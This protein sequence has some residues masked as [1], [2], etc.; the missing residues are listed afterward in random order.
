MTAFKNIKWLF[1]I[2]AFI[3]LVIVQ[4]ALNYLWVWVYSNYINPGGNQAF[5][6]IYIFENRFLINAFIAIPLYYIAAYVLSK[7][8]GI[9]HGFA[10]FA[11]HFVFSL[12]SELSM[13]DVSGYVFGFLV[14]TALI[15]VACYLGGKQGTSKFRPS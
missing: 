6:E 15:F 11:F 13:G 7:K 14:L 8:T 9:N 2:V 5:Y 4:F 1:L 10:L 12:L 3:V